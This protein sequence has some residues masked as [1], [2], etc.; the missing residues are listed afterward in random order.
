MRRK[1]NPKARRGDTSI[2]MR[3]F[4]WR[5]LR[6]QMLSEQRQCSRCLSSDDLDIVHIVSI[7]ANWK[8]RLVRS[9]VQVLCV[10]CKEDEIGT[11]SRTAGT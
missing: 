2:F 1:F 3:S 11:L 4:E 9:N 10:S 6:V 8:L 7:E 5:S